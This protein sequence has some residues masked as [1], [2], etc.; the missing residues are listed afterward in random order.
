[1]KH[2]G[3]IVLSG[4][5]WLTGG[6]SLLYKGLRFISYGVIREDSLASRFADVFGSASQAGTV[7]LAMGLLLG[8][9]KGRFVFS[10]TVSRVVQR[11]L[12]LSLP[13]RFIDVY[14]RSYWILIG[15]MIGLG[16]LIKFLPIPVDLR[17]LIDVAIGSALVNGSMLYFRFSSGLS[18]KSLG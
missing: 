13:I 4:F 2:R 6:I 18:K 8:F 9:L 3:W 17:G 1:M 11:I 14:P 7:I 5:V 12:S 10:K 16:F 15:G